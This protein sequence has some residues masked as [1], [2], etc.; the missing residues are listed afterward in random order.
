[1]HLIGYEFFEPK[2]HG[3]LW[4]FKLE[5]KNRVTVSTFLLESTSFYDNSGKRLFC[6]AE[7][8]RGWMNI[9]YVGTEGRDY[10]WTR[11]L[12]IECLQGKREPIVTKPLPSDY[13]QVA[14]PEISG[15]PEEEQPPAGPIKP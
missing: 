15:P 7:A 1:M 13:V 5:D 3:R 11:D 6:L 12:V 14:I 2:K 8:N 9:W 4:L 10:K